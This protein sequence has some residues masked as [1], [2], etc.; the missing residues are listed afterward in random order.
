[1]WRLEAKG[2]ESDVKKR[3]CCLIPTF[4]LQ[5]ISLPA[6]GSNIMFV[7]GDE[8]SKAVQEMQSAEN[9]DEI[10]ISE[11]EDED[12]E[13]EGG[14]DGKYLKSVQAFFIVYYSRRAAQEEREGGGGGDGC[15][16]QGVWRTQE[17]HCRLDQHD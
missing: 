8:Q 9:P 11:D 4:D 17:A 13:E 16:G 7:R 10:D 6:T 15:A 1:M 3:K 14:E 12:E 2:H 5:I